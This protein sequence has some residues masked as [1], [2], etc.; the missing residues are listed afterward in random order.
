M[1]YI[2]FTS[3]GYGFPVCQKLIE[4]GNEVIVAQIQ[5]KDL[6][7]TP[8]EEKNKAEPEKTEDKKIRLSLFDGILKKHDA[9]EVLK[10]MKKEDSRDWIVLTDSNN[11]FQFLEQAQKM[12]YT[13]LIP[14]EVD[15]EFEVA[16]EKAKEIVGEHY[17]DLCVM[18]HHEFKTI[19]E[20]IEFLND[21]ENI[22]VLK[23][24]G[25]SGETIVPQ[26]DD[27][28][29]ANRL[30]IDTLKTDKQS[31]EQNGYMFEQ[32]I[33]DGIELTPQIVFLDGKVVFTDLDIETKKLGGHDKGPNYGC[34]TNLVI[35]TDP[36]DKLN[37]MAFPKYVYDLAKERKG[38]FITD[39]GIIF[40]Q[41]TKKAYFT[42]FCFQRFGWD[43]LPTEMAM[44]GEEK[45]ATTYFDRV[46][47]GK[48][49]L[50][51]RFGAAVRLFNLGKHEDLS[52]TWQ[53]KV[54]PC[55]YLYDAKK[56][57]DQYLTIGFGD[58]L[59]VVTG[60]GDTIKEA[61]EEAYEYAEGVSLKDVYFKSIDDF[62]S[63][64]YPQ[65][66]LNR[67]KWAVEQGLI[68][69]KGILSEIDQLTA[70]DPTGPQKERDFTAKM[71]EKDKEIQQIKAAIR[72]AL[73]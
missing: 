29:I 14:L 8:D 62:Y 27:P 7:L 45:M 18:E 69:D 11:S 50:K 43:C 5:D 21:T 64:T 26:V 55:L 35:K 70:K 31:Y 12:G 16:R 30:I 28:Q 52:I 53:D 59:G 17:P 51:K 46:M 13:G 3:D 22:Y 1:K 34:V 60:P 63:L 71:F 15:R 48:N 36:E 10:T 24:L 33:L 56:V 72:E 58:D 44:C 23:S 65:A 38:I 4:E 39:A 47:A 42:E 9:V 32:K 61:I 54:G 49:P 67:L 20:G 40:D 41:R 25:D 37:K 73:K 2:W 66:I 19:D 68:P 6:T 57:E